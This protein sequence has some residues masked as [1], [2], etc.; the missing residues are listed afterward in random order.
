MPTAPEHGKQTKKK[1]NF[2]AREQYFESLSADRFDLLENRVRLPDSTDASIASIHQLANDD[3]VDD[4]F[5]S[6]F[7]EILRIHDPE[8]I[9]L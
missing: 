9:S 5:E 8:L 4:A 7:A 1:I 6:I 2:V 3:D